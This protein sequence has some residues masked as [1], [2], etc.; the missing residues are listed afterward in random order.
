MPF[1]PSFFLQLSYLIIRI[2]YFLSFIIYLDDTN[3]YI[4]W[5]NGC[6]KS[7]L[8][9]MM[10]LNLLS[11]QMHFGLQHLRYS[12]SFTSFATTAEKKNTVN[13]HVLLLVL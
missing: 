4:C 7:S 5:S 12:S 11:H 10:I 3:L 9:E 6:R 8:G 1:A 13:L 2:H